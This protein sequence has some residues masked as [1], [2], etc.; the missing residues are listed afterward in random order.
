MITVL[1]VIFAYVAL[2]G[3]WVA[4]LT[5]GAE[6]LLQFGVPESPRPESR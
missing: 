2:A 4:G 5:I 6:N 1:L 3:I